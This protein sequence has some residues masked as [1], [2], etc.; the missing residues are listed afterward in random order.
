M[1][2]T[3]A[4]AF[5]QA[6]ATQWL[7]PGWIP[8]GYVVLLAGRK[9]LGKSTLALDWFGRSLLLGQPFPDGKRIIPPPA[10]SYIL[11]LEAEAGQQINATRAKS[12][13]VPLERIRL[14]DPPGND[15]PFR[16]FAASTESFKWVREQAND[17]LCLGIV[18]DALSGTYNDDEN[19]AKAG[20]VMLAFADIAQA[21]SKPIL[22][23]HHK[24]KR[25]RDRDG[26]FADDSL[27]SV[28]G[29]SALVQYAR[30]VIS[31][32]APRGD[33]NPPFR[34]RQFANNLAAIPEPLGYSLAPSLAY[35]EAPEPM[36]SG[37]TLSPAVSKAAEWLLIALDG[38]EQP[39]NELF[40]A[41]ES[42][43][44]TSSSLQRAKKVLHVSS[45]Q[46]SG[47]WFWSLPDD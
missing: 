13:S 35:C 8:K 1:P 27:E 20:K 38:S 11:W 41:A 21:T 6:G 28:R 46:S 18:V 22:V 17:P 5:A 24:S 43:G 33:N 37:S 44:I 9:G 23:L 26:K 42:E 12:M 29:S 15:S 32:D 34:L 2:Q 45:R 14:F 36:N 47:V 7:W 3:L 25:Q 40:T 4:D 30:V 31:L 10:D 19:A 16:H 39:A